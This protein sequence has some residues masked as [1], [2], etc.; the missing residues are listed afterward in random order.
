MVRTRPLQ[1]RDTGSTPVEAAMHPKRQEAFKL[2]LS[3]KS[4]G[5]IAKT[6]D[7]SKGSLSLWF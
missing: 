5:E 2:R 1:G 3:G 6:L 4:Y 7:V